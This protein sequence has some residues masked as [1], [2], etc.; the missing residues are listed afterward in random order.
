MA[1]I[2]SIGHGPMKTTT[3][4]ASSAMEIAAVRIQ[5]ITASL[6]V[7]V[8]RLAPIEVVS[9]ARQPRGDRE[10][11]RC[12]GKDLHAWHLEFRGSALSSVEIFPA[13]KAWFDGNGNG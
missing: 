4:A 13:W 3:A 11:S 12:C 8:R 6:L 10:I 2:H 5:C 7:L 9:K 1:S